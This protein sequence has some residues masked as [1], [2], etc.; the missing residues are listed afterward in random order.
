M[1][2]LH[3]S[4]LLTN[5]STTMRQ[6][7][8]GVVQNMKFTYDSLVVVQCC[9]YKLPHAG[10]NETTLFFCLWP[11]SYTYY[12]FCVFS[13]THRIHCTKWRSSKLYSHYSYSLKQSIQN[14]SCSKL[15]EHQLTVLC[16]THADQSADMAKWSLSNRWFSTYIFKS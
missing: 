12:L 16:L 1:F 9:M 14:K 11:Q 10:F 8:T 3:S 15:Q 5:K 2:T 6:V 4:S 7:S 13:R